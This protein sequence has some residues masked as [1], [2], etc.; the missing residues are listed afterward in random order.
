MYSPVKG[1]L[2]CNDDDDF[3]HY[4]YATNQQY[5]AS[6]LIYGLILCLGSNFRFIHIGNIVHGG[7]YGWAIVRESK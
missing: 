1:P 5:L 3:D 4:F 2:T 6:F 7:N